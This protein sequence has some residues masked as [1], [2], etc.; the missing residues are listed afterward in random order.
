VENAGARLLVTLD[1]SVHAAVYF[2]WSL[3][4]Q[5]DPEL[6]LDHGILAGWLM[7]LGDVLYFVLDKFKQRT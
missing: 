6:E 1:L 5:S 2:G 4:G 3:Y 7:S